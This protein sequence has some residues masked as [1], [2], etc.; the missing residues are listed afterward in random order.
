MRSAL[1]RG[2]P[3][4]EPSTRRHL[5]VALRVHPLKVLD[6]ANGLVASS[7]GRALAEVGAWAKVTVTGAWRGWAW[8]EWCVKPWYARGFARSATRFLR[9]AQRSALNPRLWAAPKFP[10]EFMRDD[11]W[12]R[13]VRCRSEVCPGEA[14]GFSCRRCDTNVRV[15]PLH[16]YYRADH[17][18]RVVAEMRRRGPPV[19][20][21]AWD[22][23]GR[24]WHAREGTHRLRAALFL[25]IAPVIVPVRWT[26]SRDSIERA[27]HA[28]GR[29]AH[30]F[31][32]VEVL[33]LGHV[34]REM[35]TLKGER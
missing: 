31:P 15:N 33:S 28:A 27:R 22:E 9:I 23:E 14:G 29:Y 6:A 10:A 16:G 18:D 11:S 34:R 24:V 20:R 12:G 21:A 32:T 26:K 2:R 25:G 5:V 7:W 3:S 19:I 17:L 1:H 30:V 13:C 8:V 35:R 4:Y